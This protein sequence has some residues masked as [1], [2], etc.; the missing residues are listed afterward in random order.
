MRGWDGEKTGEQ[1]DRKER[2]W[3]V[4]ED[5]FKLFFK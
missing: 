5:C 1:V 4:K 3:Y 2:D